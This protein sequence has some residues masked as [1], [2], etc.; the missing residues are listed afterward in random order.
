MSDDLL[1]K[2]LKSEEFARAFAQEKL[3]EDAGELVATAMEE[4]GVSKAQLAERLGTSRSHITQLL[5]GSRN[6]TLR[7]LADIMFVLRKEVMLVAADRD[8]GEAPPA[9]ATGADSAG[10]PGLRPVE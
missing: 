2:E 6:M 8:D 9:C 5:R 4:H 3:I 1:H 10:P 7:T